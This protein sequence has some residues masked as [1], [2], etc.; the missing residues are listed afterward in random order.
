MFL[1]STSV[2]QADPFLYDPG[3]LIRGKTSQR[4]IMTAI[5]D[6]DIAPSLDSLGGQK[7]MHRWWG[8]RDR[9]RQ[10]GG[11]VIFKRE[12]LV[13]VRIFQSS[14]T[15]VSGTQVESWI[16]MREIGDFWRLNLAQ[17]RSFDTMGRNEYVLV[18]ERVHCSVV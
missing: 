9:T 7:G 12:E 13:V 3:Y 1:R 17:P 4:K 16:M 14:C 18:C 6:E 11:K 8:R 10:Y 2:I 5:E 15:R